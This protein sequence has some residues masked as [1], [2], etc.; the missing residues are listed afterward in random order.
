MLPRLDEEAWDALRE[1]FGTRRQWVMP[2]E[3]ANATGVTPGQAVAVLDCLAIDGVADLHLF[4]YHGCQAAPH[5]VLEAGEELGLPTTCSHCGEPIE[6]PEELRYGIA[7]L[8][9][10]SVELE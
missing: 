1:F 5:D 7:A 3:I 4:V 2:H 8:I 9:S 6:N 10:G